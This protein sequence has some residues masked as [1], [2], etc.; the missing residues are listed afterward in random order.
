MV[1]SPRDALPVFLL[2]SPTILLASMS[3][4]LAVHSDQEI[5]ARMLQES[6]KYVL[7]SNM[8]AT[9]PGALVGLHE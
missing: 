3:K 5:V 7:E 9:S 1:V 6:P 2:G 4:H 8:M